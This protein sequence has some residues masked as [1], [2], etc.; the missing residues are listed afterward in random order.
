MASGHAALAVLLAAAALMPPPA[1]AKV[2]PQPR[3]AAVGACVAPLHTYEVRFEGVA[4]EDGALE[5]LGERWH[6]LGIASGA[7]AG[8]VVRVSELG[9]GERAQHAQLGEEGYVLRVERGGAEILADTAAGRF[10]GLMTL[11]QLPMRDGA[12]WCLPQAHI[13][14][15]PAMRWRGVS[16]DVSRGP[17]PTLAFFKERIRTIAAF[18]GNLYSLYF[19]SA[20]ADPHLPLPT[21]PDAITPHE[22]RELSEYAARFHVALMPEQETLG[23]MHRLLSVEQYSGLAELPHDYVLAPAVPESGQLMRGIIADEAAQV[24]GRTPFFHVGGDEPNLVGT[25]RSADLLKRE[26]SEAMYLG[27]Y[28]PLFT[29]VT[30][31]GMRPVIW[32]DVLLAHPDAAARLP[33]NVVVANWHYAPEASYEKYLTPFASA[34]IEQFVAPGAADWGEIY[35]GLSAATENAASFVRD[36]QATPHVI[37]MLETV[38]H[39][40]GE[41][42]FANTW[43]PVL[44]ALAAAWQPA[45]IDERAFHARFDWAFFGTDEPRWADDL[46]ALRAAQDALRTTP[47]DPSNYLFWSDPFRNQRRVFAQIDVAKVRVEAERALHDLESGGAPPPLHADALLALR[48]AARRYDFLG[49]KYQIAR[50]FDAYYADALAHAGKDDERVFHDLFLARYLLWEWRDNLSVIREEY[51][52]AWQAE[53]R[54]AYLAN[55]LARYDEW[56]ANV[57]RMEDRLQAVTRERYYREDHRLP[58]REELFS[59]LGVGSES[60]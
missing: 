29:T 8:V 57:L 21:P 44:F 3:E 52:R 55:V 30:S 24:R 18:K 33:K 54:P 4:R 34:G 20:F 41:S 14:D 42:L 37:G 53:C 28:A 5:I 38:W 27:Y 11:A 13:V 49:R 47:T 7:P 43:Y 2:L 56:R 35:A 39:D 60:P 22:L 58:T 48:L 19:E 10:Y 25:G 31:L 1:Q 26:G 9:A 36:G 32:G 50:E 15:H 40:D 46:D 23:H 51:A 59:G 45:P 16:D 17:I 6:A 12:G